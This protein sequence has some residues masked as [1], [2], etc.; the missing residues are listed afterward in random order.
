MPCGYEEVMWFS[1]GLAE[2]QRNDLWYFVDR[3]GRE[4]PNE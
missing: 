3:T 4:Y 2:V 1:K